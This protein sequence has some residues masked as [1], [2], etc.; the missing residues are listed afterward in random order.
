V[1]VT[2]NQEFMALP[3]ITAARAKIEPWPSL[4]LWTDDYSSLLPILN[5]HPAPKKD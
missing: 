1:L 5:L 4:R 3:E 2:A